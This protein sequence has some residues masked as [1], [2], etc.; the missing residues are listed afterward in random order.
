MPRHPL[1]T[2]DGRFGTAEDEARDV[3]EMPDGWTSN[4]LVRSS[5]TNQFE[6]VALAIFYEFA[7]VTKSG[8][9]IN[10]FE[11]C[12]QSRAEDGIHYEVN[13]LQMGRVVSVHMILKTGEHYPRPITLDVRSSRGWVHFY[14]TSLKNGTVFVPGNLCPKLDENK[15]PG[16]WAL[17]RIDFFDQIVKPVIG[18]YLAARPTT[19]LTQY[20]M[21]YLE[22]KGITLATQLKPG[23]WPQ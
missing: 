16:F 2:L 6:S 20:I 14:V 3:M 5:E 12:W 15:Y 18:D 19:R 21:P 17:D 22:E 4:R 1:S 23:E 7:Q 10:G 13:F 8:N 11:T 9:Y